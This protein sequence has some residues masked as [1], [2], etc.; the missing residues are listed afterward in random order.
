M[1]KYSETASVMAKTQIAHNNKFYRDE[2]NSSAW[3]HKEIRYTD[4]ELIAPKYEEVPLRNV[5][6]IDSTTTDAVYAMRNEYG[7]VPNIA[8]LNFASFKYPGGMFLKGSTAQEESLCHTSTLYNVLSHGDVVSWYDHNGYESQNNR[9]LYHNTGLYLPNIVFNA[10][11]Y[12]YDVVAD[13]ITVAAPFSKKAKQAFNVSD[14]ELAVAIDQRI[15]TVFKMAIQMHVNIL[16]LGA[17]GCGVF[18]GDPEYISS[19]FKKYCQIYQDNF[20]KIIFAIPSGTRNYD[21][22]VNKLK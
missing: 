2:I 8:A 15:H 17:F 20:T 10:D 1:F 19:V 4:E 11:E 13:V 21:V 18:G 7:E 9:E 22:F 3:S 5:D 6:V 16:I 14:E 12:D